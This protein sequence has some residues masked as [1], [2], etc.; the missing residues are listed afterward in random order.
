MMMPSP[1]FG[2]GKGDTQVPQL[3]ASATLLWVLAASLVALRCYVRT[4]IVK[5]FGW[6]DWTLL[7]ALVSPG[8]RVGVVPDGQA[9][10]DAGLLA[11]A[12]YLF[13]DELVPPFSRC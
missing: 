2:T 11:G 7:A 1:G 5:A 3:I 10:D 6:E 12:Q 8:L 9:D 13:G 4:K